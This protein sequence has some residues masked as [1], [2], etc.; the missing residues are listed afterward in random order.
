MVNDEF[1]T[2]TEDI[3]MASADYY[4]CDVCGA[5]TFYDAECSYK[6]DAIDAENEKP[7]LYGVGQMR[8]LCQKC[9]E[10]KRVV[11]VDK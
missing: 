8:V 1:L 4:K 11:I 6:I 10:T 3:N 9:T 5:K 7:L 2:M